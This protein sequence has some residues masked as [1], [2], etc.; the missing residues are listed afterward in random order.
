MLW[1]QQVVCCGNLQ[2]SDTASWWRQ[3]NNAFYLTTLWIQTTWGFHNQRTSLTISKPTQAVP[4]T[5]CVL[6]KPSYIWDCVDH[7]DSKKTKVLTWEHNNICTS[8]HR[9]QN[10][11]V[12]VSCSSS[13]ITRLCTHAE[14]C[15]VACTCK[16][17]H[18]GHMNSMCGLYI[19]SV[20]A[21]VA[22]TLQPCAGGCSAVATHASAVL[23]CSI[24]WKSVYS[25]IIVE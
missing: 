16:K 15:R 24:R 9:V 21:L 6:W 13:S 1:R 14:A 2:I 3:K 7:D 19:L 12:N 17:T 22:S 20:T 4:T 8:T 25:S 5:S 11:R 18:E 10:G 23:H